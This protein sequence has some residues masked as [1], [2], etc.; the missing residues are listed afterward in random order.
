M[1]SL[2]PPLP[3]PAGGPLP[4]P[5]PYQSPASLYEQDTT[6]LQTLSIF[7]FIIA[8]IQA[9]VSLFFFIYVLIG[10]FIGMVGVAGA[11]RSSDAGVFAAM[12]GA[13]ACFGLCIIGAIWFWA[14]LNYKTGRSLRARKRLTLCYVM[15]AI[16]C[17]SF[18]FGTVLGV[19]T[20]VVLNRPSVKASFT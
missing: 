17:L 8:G 7:Y 13:M 19:F 20:F 9:A 6:N 3:P 15:A 5:V 12:G 11:Q 18:P 10:V 2:P 1:S 14:Y 4:L 16:T